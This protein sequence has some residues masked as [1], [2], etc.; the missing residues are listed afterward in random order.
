MKLKPI[1]EDS[2]IYW[3]VATTTQTEFYFSY[4]Y[5][6]KYIPAIFEKECHWKLWTAKN[7][8]H[9]EAA[10]IIIQTPER[11][12]TVVGANGVIFTIMVMQYQLALLMHARHNGKLKHDTRFKKIEKTDNGG[13]TLDL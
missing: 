11:R 1:K 13:L 5:P 6:I 8:M 7:A 9:D 12:A 3:C 4:H 2:N 10:K